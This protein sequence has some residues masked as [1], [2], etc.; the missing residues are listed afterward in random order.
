[1][2]PWAEVEA[3][4]ESMRRLREAEEGGDAY[5]DALKAVDQSL[6]ISEAGTR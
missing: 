5:N 3:A 6:G 1:M 2:S 4:R